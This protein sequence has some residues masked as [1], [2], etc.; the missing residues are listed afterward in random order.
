MEGPATPATAPEISLEIIGQEAGDLGPLK[1]QVKSITAE[2]VILEGG[3]LPPNLPVQAVRDQVGVLHMPPD[4]VIKGAQIRGKVI[5]ARHGENGSPLL[6]GLDLGEADLRARR[7]LENRLMAY[8][9]DLQEFWNHWDYIHVPLPTISSD[10]KIYFV[11]MAV[12]LGGLVLH[13][14]GP[15]H[16]KAMGSIMAFYGSL[17]IAGYSL[18]N[19]WRHRAG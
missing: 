4:G 12:F 2:G 17:V 13:F 11:G 8:P 3:H 7:L 10:P 18:W 16:F 15:N 1:V 6:L 5:W 19:M 14:T 9:R